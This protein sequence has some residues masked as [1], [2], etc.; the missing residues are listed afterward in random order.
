M[1]TPSD[2]QRHEWLKLREEE[3]ERRRKKAEWEAAAGERARDRLIDQLVIMGERL[4]L[5]R[6]AAEL[7]PLID[8]LIEARGDRERIDA[9][10]REQDM[11]AAE[12][13]AM[14]LLKDPEAA[15]RFLSQYAADSAATHA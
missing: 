5:A 6:P 2:E 3:R 10:R 14:I 15:A 7:L 9:I 11:S 8:E 13:C 1:S 4:I 12:C